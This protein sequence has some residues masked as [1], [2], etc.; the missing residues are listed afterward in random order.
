[1]HECKSKAQA[2]L[3]E[4]LSS[5]LTEPWF[6]RPSSGQG[7]LSTATR[8]RVDIY[9]FTLFA[10]F[11]GNFK[12]LPLWYCFQIPRLGIILRS[13]PDSGFNIGST[14][15]VALGRGRTKASAKRL[16][17]PPTVLQ[18]QFDKHQNVV[19]REL[20]CESPQREPAFGS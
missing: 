19:E 7:L 3:T 2:S 14:R 12:G 18:V 9:A 10:V 4:S 15:S 17:T 6:P 1:M 5:C 11:Y 20:F 8:V 16:Q 13:P